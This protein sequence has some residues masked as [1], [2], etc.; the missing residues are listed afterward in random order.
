MTL[1]HRVLLSVGEDATLRLWSV[2]ETEL[3]TRVDLPYGATCVSLAG[4]RIVVGD[5]VGNVLVFD[6][7]WP[8]V[9]GSELGAPVEARA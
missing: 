2:P 8:R 1:D 3:I 5:V 7:D 4:T 6:V 9:L